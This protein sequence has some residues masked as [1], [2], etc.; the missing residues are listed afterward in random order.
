MN[1]IGIE[2]M[3]GVKRVLINR[4]PQTTHQTMNGSYENDGMLYDYQDDALPKE[5]SVVS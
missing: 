2:N 3:S 4:Q 5:R 1:S